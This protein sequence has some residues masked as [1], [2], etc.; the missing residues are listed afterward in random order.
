MQLQKNDDCYLLK[1]DQLIDKDDAVDE[2][3]DDMNYLDRIQKLLKD[4]KIREF[5]ELLYLCD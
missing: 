2:S 4:K 1:N 5:G 3:V